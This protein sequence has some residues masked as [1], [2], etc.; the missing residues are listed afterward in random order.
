MCRIHDHVISSVFSGGL[1]QI[2]TSTLL[3]RPAQPDATIPSI[4]R[5]IAVVQPTHPMFFAG[6]ST[7]AQTDREDRP[8]VTAP[9]ALYMIH[10]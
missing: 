3:R 2:E 1:Y 4:A 8:T 7:G 6:R 9:P 5:E 10:T